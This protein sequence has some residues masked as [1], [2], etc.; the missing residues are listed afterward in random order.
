MKR[1]KKRILS[2]ILSLVMTVT[3]LN[4][5][6][7]TVKADDESFTVETG[8]EFEQTVFTEDSTITVNE[9]IYQNLVT[10]KSDVTVTY[11][12]LKDGDTTADNIKDGNSGTLLNLNNGGAFYIDLGSVKDLKQFNLH[13]EGA[14]GAKYLIELSVDGENYTP[15]AFVLN[16][17]DG[18]KANTISLT[19]VQSAQYIRIFC[20]KSKDGWGN[21]LKEFT[22]F[23]KDSTQQPIIPMSSELPADVKAI[24][25]EYNVLLNAGAV[26]QSGANSGN[27]KALIDGNFSSDNNGFWCSKGS[28]AN[29]WIIIDLGQKVKYSEIVTLLLIWTNDAGT[30]PKNAKVE[31][32]VAQNAEI[33]NPVTA[34]L[35]TSDTSTVSVD[36]TVE[37]N[38]TKV[39]ETSGLEFPSS[40]ESGEN[41][42]KS[43]IQLESNDEADEFQYVKLQM[44]ST[45]I[46]WG[47]KINEIA[48]LKSSL[49]NG[50][51][52]VLQK[53]TDL[54]KS[55]GENYIFEW[56]AVDTTGIDESC[57]FEGYNFYVGDQKINDE[58]ITDTYY[59]AQNALNED[60]LY[61]IG[62]SAVYSID[63]ETQESS[64]TTISYRVGPE[65]G[66]PGTRNTGVWTDIFDAYSDF[67]N[68]E[69][70][71]YRNVTIGT[72]TAD[73]SSYADNNKAQCDNLVD[74]KQDRWQAAWGTASNNEDQWIKIDL[75]SV[76]EIKEVAI[77]WER[78]LAQYYQVRIGTVDDIDSCLPVYENDIENVNDFYWENQWENKTHKLDRI[79]L[80]KIEKAQFIWVKTHGWL[81]GDIS[82]R[83]ILVYGDE[84]EDFAEWVRIEDSTFPVKFKDGTIA[85]G[86]MSYLNAP[87]RTNTTSITATNSG[88][89]I[90]MYIRGDKVS[91]NTSTK[92]SISEVFTGDPTEEFLDQPAATG[93]LHTY[94]SIDS[95]TSEKQE[96]YI[97]VD[98]KN[99]FT[100]VNSATAYYMLKIESQYNNNVSTDT[101]TYYLPVKIE[102]NGTVEVRAFQMNTNASEGAV[103]EFNPSFRVISRVSSNMVSPID[104]ELH[105]V[106]SFG[107][108]YTLDSAVD[109]ADMTIEK[110]EEAD[111][112][113]KYVK[114]TENGI[115][116]NWSGSINDKD[117]DAYSYYAVTFKSITYYLDMLELNYRVR[118]YAV[119]DDG[120]V[121]YQQTSNEISIYEIAQAL[122]DGGISTDSTERDFLYNNVLNIVSIKNNRSKIAAEM[123]KRLKPASSSDEKYI[124]INNLYKDFYNYINLTGEYK[125][126]SRYSQR[127][128][129]GNG[130]KES[131][132]T[133]LESL[134]TNSA[135]NYETIEAWIYNEI[136]HENGFYEKKDLTTI[137]I[138][139]GTNS[140]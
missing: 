107:T 131:N 102:L 39:Y 13:W 40:P 34:A 105:S 84:V 46:N 122:Y 69:G 75:G 43:E 24:L 66:I 133:L 7:K 78:S 83:E 140:L 32:F 94:G 1:N 67:V 119:L 25:P 58:L 136:S 4:Y 76:H 65:P 97:A 106:E 27:A 37:D 128:I 26:Y 115:L 19:N 44:D 85:Y 134:N 74:G 33:S 79:V 62:V 16:T 23:G 50:Q 81:N 113:V 111:S 71:I 56:T 99:V 3:G 125:S 14:Y 2:F 18:E 92:L 73:A 59:D 112:T 130:K 22:A 109:D 20:V 87:F 38:W 126:L 70:Q 28:Q 117:K 139:T 135:K 45:N 95:Y 110:A 80:D 138:I 64:I 10:N 114:A 54:K 30:L 100:G 118:A 123:M 129:F 42:Y 68:H 90:K 101:Y 124:Y 82:I 61:N 89:D 21:K 36:S 15:V 127:G 31:L 72:A 120:A 86:T 11:D 116:S 48:L 51:T 41:Y 52:Q 17:G 96:R 88:E 63:G 132:P 104:G 55:D 91:Y 137:N 9:I 103:S 108:L 6:P 49:N 60:G 5:V 53:P 12:N 35:G 29:N 57:I 93:A 47:I 77:D 8:S 98:S 121:I